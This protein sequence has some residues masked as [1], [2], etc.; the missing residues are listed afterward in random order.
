MIIEE[1]WISEAVTED[2][3]KKYL[4]PLVEKGIDTLLLACTHY[5]LLVPVLEK[6]LPRDVRLV[7]SATTCAEDLRQM[8]ADSDMLNAREGGGELEIH[9]T[10][11]SEQ[12]EELAKRF[13]NR[14]TGNQR[15]RFLEK[16]PRDRRKL[17]RR[18]IISLG[19]ADSR[20]PVRKYRCS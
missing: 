3:L 4:D 20:C 19:F 16:F 14:A 13:L 12:F 7:Y 18:P 17:L 8:L 15:G 10:D 2:V 1:D 11:L 5:P 9:L 6:L